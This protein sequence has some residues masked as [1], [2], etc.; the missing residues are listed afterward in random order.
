MSDEQALRRLAREAITA[1]RVPMGAPK[2]TWGG[3]GAGAL[4]DICG[5][6]IATH[7]LGFEVEFLREAAPSRI[8]HLH[9]LCFAAWELERH[10]LEAEQPRQRSNGRSP[11]EGGYPPA[12]GSRPAP[13][14]E[15][16]RLSGTDKAGSMPH[17]ERKI[18]DG[19][20][21]S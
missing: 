21:S 10:V 5:L 9:S 20:E 4:C 1:E 6:S 7:E 15:S 13:A 14:T 12:S 8:Y 17:S 16:H 2:A 11:P 18:K 3:N 19:G